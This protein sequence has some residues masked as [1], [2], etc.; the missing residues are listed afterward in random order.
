MKNAY[1]IS[2]EN[3]I[4]STIHT[5]PFLITNISC[6]NGYALGYS[7]KNNFRR[8]FR[9]SNVYLC[10]SLV[11]QSEAYMN[12]SIITHSGEYY[13]GNDLR[14][15][16]RSTSFGLLIVVNGNSGETIL[17]QA[18]LVSYTSQILLLRKH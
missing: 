17:I 14:A 3:P 1:D 6:I 13:K 5:T 8:G 16:S 10:A 18:I 11:V 15:K 4:M 9:L 2:N 12:R 7:M